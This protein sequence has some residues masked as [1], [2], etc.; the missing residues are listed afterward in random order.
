MIIIEKHYFNVSI[1]GIII[2]NQ[3][4]SLNSNTE[5]YIVVVK[6]KIYQLGPYDL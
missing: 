4:L 6:N 2:A 3:Y 1:L 5:I